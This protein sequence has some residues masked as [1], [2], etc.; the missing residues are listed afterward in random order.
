MSSLDYLSIIRIKLINTLR[1]KDKRH[2]AG[3]NERFYGG[4]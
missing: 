1:I 3:L 4:E 2:C